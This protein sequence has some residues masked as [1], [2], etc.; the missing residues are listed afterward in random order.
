VVIGFDKLAIGKQ[1]LALFFLGKADQF[2]ELEVTADV[3]TKLIVVGLFK[4]VN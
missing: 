4:F 2:L 3:L 1:Q